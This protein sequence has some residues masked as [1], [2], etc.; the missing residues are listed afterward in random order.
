MFSNPDL[1]RLI[2][3]RLS[4]ELI[5]YQEPILIVTFAAVALGGIIV[6]W[7]GHLFPPM[8]LSLAR[9]VHERRS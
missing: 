6:L 5:P 3:G 4:L 9:V 7:P 1:Q 8:G 2:F